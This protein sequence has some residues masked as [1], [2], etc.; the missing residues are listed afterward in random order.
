[1]ASRCNLYV[2]DDMPIAV[3]FVLE[4]AGFEVRSKPKRLTG[5]GRGM[6]YAIRRG[7][8]RASVLE[9][10]GYTT[11][12]IPNTNLLCSVAT[13]NTPMLQWVVD[14]LKKAGACDSRKV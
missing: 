10:P 7:K 1:M 11:A 2:P 5:G 13:K 9:T 12:D 8:D 3:E 4:E 6:E 14:A